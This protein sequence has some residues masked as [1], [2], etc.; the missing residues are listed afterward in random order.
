MHRRYDFLNIPIEVLRTLIVVQ[1]TGSFTKAAQQLGISQ[2]AISAQMKRLQQIVGG[3]VFNAGSALPFLTAKGAA[4]AQKAQQ[5]VRLN[6]LIISITS[7]AGRGQM[8]KVGIPNP[9]SSLLIEKLLEAT[10]EAE[11]AMQFVCDSS[12]NL[13]TRLASGYLDIAFID[14]APPAQ[15]RPQH[16]W[17]EQPAWFCAE[18]FRLKAGAELPLLSWP[19]T[20]SD[21]MAIRICEANELSY[22]FVFE[23]ADLSSHLSALRSGAG[24]L[25]LPERNI[26]AGLTTV[27]D[28]MLPKLPSVR[29][30]IYMHMDSEP[31]HLQPVVDQLAEVLAP[32]A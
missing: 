31:G 20:L 5:I 13:A 22:S 14:T 17:T 18:D 7:G 24:L 19:R 6:D 1:D 2:P 28:G 25:I 29:A 15:L 8:I 21:E 16:V 32:A 27:A 23:A 3:N 11:P 30:G 4:I 9:Y 12:P 26:A 10:R